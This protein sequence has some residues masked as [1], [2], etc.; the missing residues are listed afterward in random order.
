MQISAE[1]WKLDREVMNWTRREREDGVV[2]GANMRSYSG[3][4]EN[5]GASVNPLL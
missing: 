1:P 2:L 3:W 5:L 4:G